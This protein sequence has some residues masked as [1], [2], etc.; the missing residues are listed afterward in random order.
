MTTINST[1]SNSSISDLKSDNLSCPDLKSNGFACSEPCSTLVPEVPLTIMPSATTPNPISSVETKLS[2]LESSSIVIC[3]TKTDTMH[4]LYVRR[5]SDKA[6][7]P[8]RADPGAAGYDLASAVDIVVPARGKQLI[9]T[10]LSMTIPKN[11]YGRVAPRSGLAWKNHIDVG[12]GV[13]DASYVG[14]VGVILFNHGENDLNVKVGDRIAQ[15]IIEPILTPEVV[16]VSELE[17]TER[18]AG[19]FGSTGR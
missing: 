3:T 14:C 11:H 19:G 9:S 7:I 16:E 4:R 17:K 2:E 6:I 1:T 12:G 10:D 5:L 15:L 18:G 8:K 13:I